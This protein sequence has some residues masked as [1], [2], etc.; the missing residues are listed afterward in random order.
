MIWNV[1]AILT[2][3]PTVLM[4]MFGIYFVGTLLK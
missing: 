2:M 4:C 3:T 1:M